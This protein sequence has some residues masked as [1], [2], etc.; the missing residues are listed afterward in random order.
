[1]GDHSYKRVKCD[2]TSVE[3]EPSKPAQ[4]FNHVASGGDS[5]I[6]CNPDVASNHFIQDTSINLDVEENLPVDNPQLNEDYQEYASEN[7]GGFMGG[8]SINCFGEEMGGEIIPHVH[9]SSEKVS[10]IGIRGTSKER[11]KNICPQT[12]IHQ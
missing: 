5:E 11:G 12:N 2:A 4:D 10:K 1:M 8:E 6:G 7:N 3:N 9:S